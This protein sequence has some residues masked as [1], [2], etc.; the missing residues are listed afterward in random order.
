MVLVVSVLVCS[1]ISTAALLEDDFND[2]VIDS[3]IWTQVNTGGTMDERDPG[4]LHQ[5]PGQYT[6][7]KVRSN[8]KFDFFAGE[9]T[10][11]ADLYNVGPSGYGW[12]YTQL[13]ASLWVS[14]N[15]ADDVSLMGAG[16]SAYGFGVVVDHNYSANAYIRTRKIVNGTA[17]DVDARTRISALDDGNLPGT[18]TLVM[19]ATNYK[20]LVN[21][22]EIF[23][24]TH[25]LSTSNYSDGGRFNLGARNDQPYGGVYDWDNASVVPEPVTIALLGLGVLGLLRRR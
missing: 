15:G 11:Q 7:L 24:G 8:D 6:V 19:D 14:G 17:S 25:G 18:I 20:V 13:R 12:G 16:G 3:T 5:A 21:D 9:K 1:G 23:S 4:V 10:F 2:N 22:T